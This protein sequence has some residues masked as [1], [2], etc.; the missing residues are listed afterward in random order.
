MRTGSYILLC[1]IS[2]LQLS[3]C[4]VTNSTKVHPYLYRPYTLKQ[5]MYVCQIHP[6]YTAGPKKDRFVL[7]DPHIFNPLCEDSLY[8][9]AYRDKPASWPLSHGDFREREWLIAKLP[10]GTQYR[11]SQYDEPYFGGE[12]PIVATVTIINGP[13]QGLK[14]EWHWYD[15]NRET[16]P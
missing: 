1:L 2:I 10:K 8:N 16:R 9:L 12:D 3:A 7:R 5:T 14:A 4:V 11:I 6:S 13:Q 15:L